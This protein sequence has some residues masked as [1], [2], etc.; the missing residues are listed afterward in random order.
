[1][2]DLGFLLI[3]FFVITAE[4]T[5]P[6]VMDIYVPKEGGKPMPIGE[7]N[8]LTVLLEEDKFYYYNGQWEDAIQGGKIF[9]TTPSGHSA[10]RKIIGDKQRELDI[11]Q[12]AKEGRDGLMVIIKPSPNASYSEVVKM[13]DEMTISQVKKFVIVKITGEEL[14]WLK[15]K[16]GSD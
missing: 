15:G 11:T 3:T 4:L 1:M 14:V 7:S 12:K 5:K 6:T 8:A 10:L 9:E 2:V 13:L 16:S